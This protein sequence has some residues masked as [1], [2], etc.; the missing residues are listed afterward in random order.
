M[1][2]LIPNT[3][4]IVMEFQKLPTKNNNLDRDFIGAIYESKFSGQKVTLVSKQV[5]FLAGRWQTVCTIDAG[6]FGHIKIPKWHF[7]MYYKLNKEEVEK[8]A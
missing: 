1:Q 8:N 7:N 5:E 2:I 4:Q 6:M 3:Q